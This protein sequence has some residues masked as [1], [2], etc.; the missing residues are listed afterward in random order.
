M[1]NKEM[2]WKLEEETQQPEEKAVESRIDKLALAEFILSKLPG[3]LVEM[4]EKGESPQNL[5]TMWENR[6]LKKENQALKKRL[7][8][9]NGKP[10]KLASEGDET[11][12][13]P[14]IAGFIQAMD[15][16]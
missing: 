8:K 4:L 11:E 7:S 16:Y 13:D 1:E 14:F 5:I 6:M 9:E 15:N 10:L 2:K 12:K 3:E